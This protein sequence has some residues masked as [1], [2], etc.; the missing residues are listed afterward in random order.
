MRHWLLY[1]FLELSVIYTSFFIS[2]RFCVP[3]PP[4]YTC[5]ATTVTACASGQYSLGQASICTDCP[6][7]SYCPSTT[8]QSLACPAGFYSLANSM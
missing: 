4:G 7:G 1:Y 2:H 5:T 6:A 8:Y 3:C